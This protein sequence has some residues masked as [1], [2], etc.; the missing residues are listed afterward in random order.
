MLLQ[1]LQAA[2]CLNLFQLQAQAL[3]EQVPVLT[4]RRISVVVFAVCSRWIS[5]VGA[6]GA[7][8]TGST[9]VD[10]NG[11]TGSSCTGSG[12]TTSDAGVTSVCS[13]SFG[14]SFYTTSQCK[15]SQDQGTD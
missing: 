11:S 4:S 13:S 14:A 1:V 15:A 12:A 5:T 8:S 2:Q 3:I 10:S 9:G 7:S 6:A